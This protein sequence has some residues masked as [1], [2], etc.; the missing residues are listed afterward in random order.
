M[1]QIDIEEY[2]LR[3]ITVLGC[4]M[5]SLIS[6]YSGKCSTAKSCTEYNQNIC[7]VNVSRAIESL[8][9]RSKIFSNFAC[10]IRVKHVFYKNL[11]FHLYQKL[12]WQGLKHTI[13]KL[14]L[15]MFYGRIQNHTKVVLS[16]YFLGATFLQVTKEFL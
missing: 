15:K 8:S 4:N 5:H 3:S 14:H 7:S 13:R 10:F 11:L 12:I 1:T 16:C 6:N 2:S 9:K